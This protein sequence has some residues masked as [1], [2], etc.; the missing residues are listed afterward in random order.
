MILPF[1]FLKSKKRGKK[2]NAHKKRTAD[3]EKEDESVK[4]EFTGDYCVDCKLYRLKYTIEAA[5]EEPTV[6]DRCID[7]LKK[8]VEKTRNTG[9]FKSLKP[10]I[11]ERIFSEGDF[12]TWRSKIDKESSQK[13]FALKSSVD[14]IDCT[15]KEQTYRE[16]A[17]ELFS[18]GNVY[19]ALQMLVRAREYTRSSVRNAIILH[20]LIKYGLISGAPGLDYPPLFTQLHRFSHNNTDITLGRE[21]RESEEDLHF[22]TEILP[23][24]IQA[25]EG[26]YLLFAGNF[27]EAG[28]KLLSFCTESQ[29]WRESGLMGTVF[30]MHDAVVYITLCF[31]ASFDRKTIKKC[32][33]NSPKFHA[34]EETCPEMTAILKAFMGL[35]YKTFLSL[36]SKVPLKYD[37]I[38]GK[39]A[40]VLVQKIQRQTIIQFIQPYSAVS[41]DRMADSLGIP[42]QSILSELEQLIDKGT[43]DAKIDSVGRVI[44]IK[45][46]SDKSRAKT[47]EQVFTAGEAFQNLAET[48]LM[49]MSLSKTTIPSKEDNTDSE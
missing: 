16:M 45:W 10:D 25:L 20:D 6:V 35:Q 40:D 47:I 18:V 19:D 5:K 43:V 29:G 48:V 42:I 28:L 4:M 22:Y 32:L 39:N 49:R 33:I 31:L 17:Q 2:E 12:D 46:D 27:K 9:F 13:L 24:N 44:T 1:L 7:E 34:W 11:R 30:S 14:K 8:C 26:V 41:F 36:V 21:V 3:R 37:M 23:N 38:I 15:D